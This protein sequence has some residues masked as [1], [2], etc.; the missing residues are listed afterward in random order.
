MEKGQSRAPVRLFQ[1]AA[2]LDG[3]RQ[4]FSQVI[5][6]PVPGFYCTR[7][8]AMDLKSKV[9]LITGGTM[10]LGAAIAIELA[11]RGADIA[12]AARNLGAPAEEVKAAV[13][14][15]GRKCVTIAADFTKPE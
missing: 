7:F 5:C 14:A 11:R 9:V 15:A 3:G 4:R 13:A 1:S 12:I 10:G 2:W 6:L 8:L